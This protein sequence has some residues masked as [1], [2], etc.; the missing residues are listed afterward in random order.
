MLHSISL[1]VGLINQSCHQNQ[2]LC[3]V[4]MTT[5]ATVCSVA[6]VKIV[7]EQTMIIFAKAGGGVIALNF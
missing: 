4:T 1:L 7:D 5:L 3:T 2:K 6:H